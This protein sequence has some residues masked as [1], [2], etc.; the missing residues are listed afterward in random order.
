MKKNRLV[1]ITDNLAEVVRQIMQSYQTSQ[2]DAKK[3]AVAILNSLE[4][5]GVVEVKGDDGEEGGK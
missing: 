5:A 3:V 4:I 2:S 1:E